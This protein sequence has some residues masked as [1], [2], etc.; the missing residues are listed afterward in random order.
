MSSL[1]STPEAELNTRYI[2]LGSF[3]TI[4]VVLLSCVLPR[5]LLNAWIALDSLVFAPL[6][7]G[8]WRRLHDVPLRAVVSG[9]LTATLTLV[10]Y[11]QLVDPLHSFN[12]RI[13]L[14]CISALFVLW[15]STEIWTKKNSGAKLSGIALVLI[16]LFSAYVFA[17][18]YVGDILYNEYLADADLD[19]VPEFHDERIWLLK[20]Y[21]VIFPACF[22]SAGLGA[23]LWRSNRLIT[24]RK[25]WADATPLVVGVALIFALKVPEFVTTGGIKA[26]IPHSFDVKVRWD[27]QRDTLVVKRRASMAV[28]ADLQDS[29]TR[30]PKVLSASNGEAMAREGTLKDLSRMGTSDW[31]ISNVKLITSLP[32][33]NI[34]TYFVEAQTP[35]QPVEI[36]S[37]GFF[38]NYA[39]IALPTRDKLV[40]DDTE[41]RFLDITISVP[42]WLFLHQNT[43]VQFSDTVLANGELGEALHTTSIIDDGDKLRLV[44]ARKIAQNQIFGWLIYISAYGK[45]NFILLGIT[46]FLLYLYTLSRQTLEESWIR[47]FLEKIFGVK[48]SDGRKE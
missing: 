42:R 43:G 33:K 31:A 8:L 38:A 47:P 36:Q 3:L 14:S 2:W 20:L 37:S 45:I 28:Q 30:K 1:T 11:Q 7:I 27:D 35:W 4:I 5:T 34:A 18:L 44:F 15:L 46:S 48:N 39:E 41:S 16:S 19:F 29:F 6:A 26:V 13:I 25:I 10:A 23:L 9:F 22:L 40:S 12:V 17:A 24:F 32:K 21:V